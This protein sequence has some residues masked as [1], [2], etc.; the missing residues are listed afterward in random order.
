MGNKIN[1]HIEEAILWDVVIGLTREYPNDYDLG[2][3]VRQLV[4]RMTDIR[5]L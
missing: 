2:D 4:R 3:Q 1:F 5:S